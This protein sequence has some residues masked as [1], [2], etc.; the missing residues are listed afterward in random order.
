[1][2]AAE[3]SVDKVDFLLY[4][5]LLSCLCKVSVAILL[6]VVTSVCV[7]V[8]YY[9]LLKYVMC[10]FFVFPPSQL[11]HLGRCTTHENQAALQT[12]RST[13]MMISTGGG[14]RSAGLHRS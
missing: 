3:S 1:M 5:K 10:L 14:Q 8:L 7:C 9:Y 4:I 6:T 11:L 12:P 13:S 2:S